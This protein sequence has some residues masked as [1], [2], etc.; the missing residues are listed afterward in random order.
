MSAEA[1]VAALFTL[2]E[3]HGQADYVGEPVSQLQHM[4][5]AAQLAR[6]DGAD[7][8]LV[9]AAFCHDVGHFCGAATA[10][11]RM[12]EF[13]RKAHERV[14][15]HWLHRLGFPQRLCGLV[16]GHV[17]AKRYLCWRD[18]DYLAGL[19]PA[20]LA[21]L[22]WQ[23]GPLSP[24]EARAFEQDPLFADSLRLRRWDE[25]AKRADAPEPDVEWLRALALRVYQGRA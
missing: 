14:G 19:S 25:A 18:A 7:D 6:Q 3:A 8:E 4:V 20:S 13:G 12:G 15:S 1:A 11:N 23:G 10:H 9:L 21:T 16:E 2:F 17:R 5:Q 24:A 22:A